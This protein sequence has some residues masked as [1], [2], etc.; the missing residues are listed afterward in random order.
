M[1][2]LNCNHE[3]SL[4]YCPSCGQKTDTHRFSIKYILTHDI[5]H[6]IF[7]IDRGF[8]HTLKE[9]FTRPGH[10][11]REYVQGKRVRHFHFFTFI[12]IVLLFDK[13][14][15]KLSD[16]DYSNLGDASTRET[17]KAFASFMRDYSK[18]FALSIIPFQA[19]VSFAFFRKAK[20]NYSE[21]LVISAYMVG[22]VLCFRIITTAAPIF[23]T[24]LSILGSLFWII[25]LL[26][27]LYSTWFFYQ[28]FASFKAYSKFG[29]FMRSF[30]SSILALVV[31]Y[32]VILLAVI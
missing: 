16:F 23:I 11:I 9:L 31:T 14:F 30:I 13:L 29:T 7:H 32:L 19:L 25:E 1:N 21:H 6:G 20:Q 27:I 18:V 17:I 4:K 22:A 15:S 12:I 8:P 26:I 3:V 2:C 10:A 5:L 28:Y 24:N